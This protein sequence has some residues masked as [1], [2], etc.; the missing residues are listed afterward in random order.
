MTE[1]SRTEF[2]FMPKAQTDIK[3]GKILT[4]LKLCSLLLALA[5]PMLDLLSP[6]LSF[7]H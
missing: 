6:L 2:I 7:A 4:T 3:T 1:K 5:R